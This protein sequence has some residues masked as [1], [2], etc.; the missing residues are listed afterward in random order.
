[1]KL[2]GIGKEVSR[3]PVSNTTAKNIRRAAGAAKRGG[4]AIRQPVKTKPRQV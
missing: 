2:F 3:T 4:T 1:V